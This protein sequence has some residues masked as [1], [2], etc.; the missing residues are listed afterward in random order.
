MPEDYKGF[1][2]LARVRSVA[3]VAG[4]IL[5]SYKSGEEFLEDMK[6]FV[7]YFPEYERKVVENIWKDFL[8]AAFEPHHRECVK[9]GSRALAKIYDH[10]I[11][12]IDRDYRE[13]PRRISSRL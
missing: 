5:D 2:M 13:N 1:E 3:N 11:E 9:A 8:L 7:T 4:M 6:N 12:I 10:L